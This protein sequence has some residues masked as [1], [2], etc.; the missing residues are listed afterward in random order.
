[1]TQQPP[2]PVPAAPG[3]RPSR[4]KTTLTLVGVVAVVAVL[5]GAAQLITKITGRDPLAGKGQP[6]AAVGTTPSAPVP[7][8]A[9]PNM[10]TDPQPT[11]EIRHELEEW[12]LKSAGVAAD[13]KS[14]CKAPAGFSGAQAV[15]FPCTVN[16]AKLAVTYEVTTKPAGSLTFSWDATAAKTVVTRAGILAAVAGRF[17]APTFSDLRCDELPEVAL[18]ATGTPLEQHCYVRMTGRDKTAWV[19]VVPT[20]S[21]PRLDTRLQ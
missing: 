3:P 6:V 8:W 1:M 5:C 10:L 15:T 4:K 12:L 7:T 17:K 14:A 13:L 11:L 21:E 16:Y 19:D 9:P 18:V 20:R 2:A